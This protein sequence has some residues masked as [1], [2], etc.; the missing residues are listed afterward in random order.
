MTG[1][2]SKLGL[3][4]DGLW[5]PPKSPPCSTDPEL[6]SDAQVY[7]K[8][9]MEQARAIGVCVFEC[10]FRNQCLYYALKEE[11]SKTV[12]ERFGIRGGVLPSDRYKRYK[13]YGLIR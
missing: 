5:V 8:N 1:S 2:K 11:G 13:K 4:A 9:S 3:L 6:W 7:L 12:K 10:Q